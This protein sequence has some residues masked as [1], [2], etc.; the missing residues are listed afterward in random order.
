MYYIDTK[1]EKI[2]STQYCIY[3]GEKA[4]IQTEWDEYKSYDHY[5]CKCE[6]ANLEN[7]YVYCTDCKNFIPDCELDCEGCKCE[8][9]NCHDFEDSRNGRIKF[10]R[11]DQEGSDLKLT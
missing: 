6:I 3:C 2:G 7:E 10:E 1:T 8:H 9:C 4:I 11:K 5:H